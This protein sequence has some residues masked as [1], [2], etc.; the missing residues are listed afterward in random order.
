M[1]DELAT[2][3][4]PN[5]GQTANFASKY[6]SKYKTIL[7]TEIELAAMIDRESRGVFLVNDF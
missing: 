1:L 6:K 2:H 7:P 4:V 3:C 5:S